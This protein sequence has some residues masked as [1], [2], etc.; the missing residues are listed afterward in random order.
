MNAVAAYA[1][2]PGS[3]FNEANLTGFLRH[4]PFKL[5]VYA[6]SLLFGKHGF[7]G[8]DLPLFLALAAFVVLLGRRCREWP[9]LAF[10]LCWCGGT[11]LMYAAFSN[12]SS[13]AAARCAGSC[14]SWRRAITPSPCC[15]ATCRSTAATSPS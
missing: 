10:G 3:P 15:C 1:N 6:L 9:E 5:A 11:W 13:S 12:N 4:G 8:H 7:V 2:W 14:P